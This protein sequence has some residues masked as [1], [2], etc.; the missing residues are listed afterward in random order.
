MRVVSIGEILWDVFQDGE[1]LGGAPFN[2]S[3]HAVRLGHDVLMVSAVGDDARGAAALQAAREL[4]VSTEYL[5]VV[6]GAPTG[7]V[8]VAL[9][10]EGKPNFTIHRPAAYDQVRL[11]EDDLCALGSFD[12]QFVCFGTL[13]QTAPV[14]KAMTQLVIEACPGAR[15]FY[16][17][18]LRRDS[19]NFLLLDE[20]LHQADVV[21]LNEDEANDLSRMFGVPY[22]SP[23]GFCEYWSARCGWEMA[24][25]SL[26]DKGCLLHRGDEFV[27][28]PG[29]PVE[30]VDTV[31]SGD[32]FSAAMLHGISQNWPLEEVADFSNRVGALVASR[33]G[34]V[35]AWTIEECRALS[36]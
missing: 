26:G 30:V 33:P 32:A 18:N 27:E 20:L 34:A 6:P 4:G 17:V 19:Y 13:H 25:L 15:R 22:K 16:D 11:T 7:I 12:P 29:Y 14:A 28:S 10:A 31:G 36:R 3:A 1:R 8:S 2:V 21:K 5:R 23:R 35:P 24:A 9:D